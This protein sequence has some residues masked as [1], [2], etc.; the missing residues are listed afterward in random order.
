MYRDRLSVLVQGAYEPG[1]NQPE[2]SWDPRWGTVDANNELT[3]W[4]EP[5]YGMLMLRPAPTLAA[6]Q[7]TSTG[8]YARLTKSDCTFG[9]AT[10]WVNHN[11]NGSA[12]NFLRLTDASASAGART[13]LTNST[14]PKNRPFYLAWF[15]HSWGLD[16][17]RIECG[18]NNAVSGLIGVSLRLYSDGEAEVWKDGMLQGTYSFGPTNATEAADQR[19]IGLL[20]IPTRRRELLVISTTGGGFAH[21][22][23]DIAETDPDPTITSASKF[24]VNVP[25]GGADIEL[26]P[27]RFAT[28]GYRASRIVY[29]RYPPETGRTPGVA[30][31]GWSP[32]YGSPTISAELRDATT[33][34]AAFVPNGVTSTARVAATMA[35]DGESTPFVYAVECGFDQMRIETPDERQ[36]VTPFTRSARLVVPAEP[37]GVALE[38][39]LMRPAALDP[40]DTNRV[41]SVSNRPLAIEM[42]ELT[43]FEGRTDPIE[44]A[45]SVTD[46]TTIIH[47]RV[48]DGFKALEQYRFSDRVPLGGGD[49]SETIRF[50]AAHGASLPDDA[51]DVPTIGYELP[52]NGPDAQGRWE[53]IIEVGDTALDWLE[54]LHESYCPNYH[55]GFEPTA[56]GVRFRWI[57]PEDMPTTPA[58]TIY[59]DFEQALA[60]SGSRDEARRLTYRDYVEEW[61]EPEANEIVVTGLDR[62]SK[63]PI[64]AVFVDQLSQDPTIPR[65]ERPDNWLGERRK[66]A[67]MD[68]ALTTVEACERARDLLVERLTRRRRLCEWTGRML[69]GPDD[70]PLWRGA[71]VQLVRTTDNASLTMI[72]RIVSFDVDI[73]RE[74]EEVEY[75]PIRRARYVAE[76][77]PLDAPTIGSGHS[78]P[79]RSIEEIKRLLQARATRAMLG[80]SVADSW[81]L[82]SPR[83]ISVRTE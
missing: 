32:G 74:T 79:G 4:V 26:A 19:M 7:T 11:A 37:Y 71:L 72:A 46:E 36:D 60:A 9:D 18:W 55:W 63:R 34:T 33:P 57:G 61:I 43:V 82:F 28:S 44:L 59:D 78:L 76:V 66:Y 39:E 29:F 1:L 8:I 83:E 49:L 6:W 56:S 53:A 25:I 38:L 13:I 70:V 64:Q 47:M 31:F 15:V 73:V 21:T 20:L 48:R 40:D 54:R 81:I 62:R 41:L 17:Y 68:S 65:A 2:P 30:A 51:L 14:W 69:F 23:E 42:G 77:V 75:P 58:I 3:T 16:R 50:L 52:F 80:P 5:I 22:F 12:S 24:W 67:W 27:L 10:K 45:R 35:S